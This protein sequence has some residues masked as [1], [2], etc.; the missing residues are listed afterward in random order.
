MII[1]LAQEEATGGAVVLRSHGWR[2]VRPGKQPPE[3]A[4][5]SE[6]FKT[7]LLESIVGDLRKSSWINLDLPGLLLS[8]DY[9]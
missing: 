9:V 3:P 4:R 1:Q 8:K 7:V 5:E 2:A 6:E